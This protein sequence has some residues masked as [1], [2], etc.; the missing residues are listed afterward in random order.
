MG[1]HAKA[2]GPLPEFYYYAGSKAVPLTRSLIG[3]S[4][5]CLERVGGI[6]DPVWLVDACRDYYA[7]GYIALPDACIPTAYHAEF[8]QNGLFLPIFDHGSYTI[9]VLPAIN[10]YG[11]SDQRQ[12]VLDY[13]TK[14]CAQGFDHCVH[15]DDPAKFASMDIQFRSG[16]GLEAYGYANTIVEKLGV[17]SDP[18]FLNLFKR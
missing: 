14:D 12:V 18:H 3:W 9:V 17:K 10:V 1:R 4:A 15:G 8:L 6:C 16:S 11:S 2:Y 5:F 13:L 7:N